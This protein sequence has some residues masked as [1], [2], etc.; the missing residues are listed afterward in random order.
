MVSVTGDPAVIAREIAA[1]RRRLAALRTEE[2][3]LEASLTSLQSQ[4]AELEKGPRSAP[5]AGAAVTSFIAILGQGRPVLQPVQ[6]AHRC[7]P[8]A[9]GK[10]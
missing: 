10:P 4:L 3:A 5:F 2:A 6:G 7:L 1:V 8:A 9:L